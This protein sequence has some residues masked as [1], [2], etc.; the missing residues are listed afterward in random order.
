[1][2]R[3]TL[4]SLAGAAAL[5]APGLAPRAHAAPGGEVDLLLLLAVD[6]SRSMDEE[7]ARFQRE[8]YAAALQDPQ[9]QAAI[10]DGPHGAIAL[11]YLEW[12]GPEHQSL[13]L[14]WRRIGGAAEA[15]GCA[16]RLRAAPL[17]IGTWTSISAALDRARETIAAAPFAAD[18][19]VIDV[20]GDGVNNAG[21]AVEDARD[22]AVAAGIVINGL[23]VMKEAPGGLPF[24]G[25]TMPLDEYYREQVVGGHG[26]FV[27]P[28]GDFGSFGVAVRRKLILEIAGVGPAARTA[29]G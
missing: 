24:G 10:A 9:V 18:R 15:A 19:H 3:R 5:A 27:L 23:P 8:G 2:R 12:S 4:L 17:T 22:R 11:A 29:F 28:A 1:M 20:S 26:A 13:L 6:V 14:P 21:A 16:D 25:G 7:E